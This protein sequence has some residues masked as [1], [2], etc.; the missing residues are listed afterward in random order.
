MKERFEAAGGSN[1]ISALLR[2]EFVCGSPTI[3]ERLLAVGT[4][5]EFAV[6]DEL[7]VEGG[8]DND[9]FLLL[10]GSVAIVIKGLQVNTR[11][12]G[13]HVGEMAAIE[14]SQKRS[15]TV[16][17]QDTVVALRISSA[18]LMAIGNDFPQIWLPIARILSRRLFE[19]NDL[20]T[21]PNESPRLFIISSAEAL[22]VAYE[23]ATQLERVALPTVWAHGTFFAGQYTLEALENA[24]GQSDFAVAIAQPDDLVESRQLSQPTVR[25][26]VIFEL[27]LFMGH[28]SR[29]RAIL[30]HPRVSN[31]KLPS[32]VNGLTLVSYATGKPEDLSARLTAPCHEIRK[33]IQRLGVRTRA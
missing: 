8:E 14:P 23:V 17:A 30:L 3:A 33:I 15:A 18:E 26:N 20:L 4:L 27:G 7:I 32:D 12:A 24:V 2:Q 11:V 22:S 5:G 21:P 29:H 28:L 16:V 9:L 13:Q 1:L 6:G 10:S 31:L 25:D 19:R